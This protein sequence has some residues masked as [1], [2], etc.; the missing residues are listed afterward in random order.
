M[1]HPSILYRLFQKQTKNI[2]CVFLFNILTLKSK[3]RA[4]SVYWFNPASLLKGIV[5]EKLERGK[6]RK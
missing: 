6:S 5:L 4:G 3:E 2:L 1:K